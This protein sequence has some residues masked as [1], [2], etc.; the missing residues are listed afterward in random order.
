[1]ADY[2]L[3]SKIIKR[4]SGQSAVAAAAYRSGLILND[5]RTGVRH[6]YSRKSGVI[7]SEILAPANTPEWMTD[8]AKLWN[9]VEAVETRKNSQLSREIQLSLPHELS[10]EQRT[11]LVQDFVQEQFVSLGMIADVNIHTPN[12]KGDERNHHAHVMLTMRELTSDGFASSKSTPTARSWNDKKLLATWREEWA[13]HQNNTLEKHGHAERV[14]HRSYEDQGIDRQ[15]EFHRGVAANDMLVKGKTSRIETKNL[16]IRRRNSERAMSLAEAAQ[17]VAAMAE[18]QKTVARQWAERKKNE[19]SAQKQSDDRE[20][21]RQHSAQKKDLATQHAEKY[22]VKTLKSEVK[23]I[24]KRLSATGFRN[25]LRSVFGATSKDQVAKKEL[26]K[27]IN[28]AQKKM[29]QEKHALQVK[30]AEEKMKQQRDQRRQASQIQEQTKKRASAEFSQEFAKA[31]NEPEHKKVVQDEKERK[32]WE[33]P[34]PEPKPPE[35]AQ[36]IAQ[37][38]RQVNGKSPAANDTVKQADRE[39]SAVMGKAVKT[40]KTP[41]KASNTQQSNT[42]NSIGDRW[43]KTKDKKPTQS[44]PPPPP[45]APKP[46]R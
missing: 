3:S 25:T 41:D 37:R 8:R 6:D 19:L 1:M 23:A 15:P 2:R 42:G 46:R 29:E 30:Q 43:K 40:E 39:W 20:L 32:Q 31:R 21:A 16:K 14:D 10:Q 9:A 28:D 34:K 45:P 26:T 35:E 4:S 44:P 13:R 7:H 17:L 36:K 18:E 12:P 22:N 27:A 38:W 24:D 5:E 33:Q 11:K